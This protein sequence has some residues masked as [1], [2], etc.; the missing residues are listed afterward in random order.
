MCPLASANSDSVCASTSRFSSLSRTVH[1]SAGNDGCWIKGRAE[2]LGQVAYDDVGAVRPQRVGVAGPVD[3]D[4]EA[5]A[6]G[7]PGLDAG[8]CVLEH[9]SVVGRDTEDGRAA[10]RY[11]SGAGLPAR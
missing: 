3:A 11:V 1:G 2:E 7:P 4:N 5:E 9:G 6:S 10:A 8:Q